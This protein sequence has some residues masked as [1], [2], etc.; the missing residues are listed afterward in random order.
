M[1]CY[2]VPCNHFLPMAVGWPDL[3]P[4]SRE[5]LALNEPAAYFYFYML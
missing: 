2:T 5:D 1:W 4:S 3:L